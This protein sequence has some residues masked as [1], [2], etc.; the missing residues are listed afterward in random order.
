M[1]QGLQPRSDVLIA[2]LERTHV[3]VFVALNHCP[4]VI[5]ATPALD[6]LREEISPYGERPED[7]LV[8]R[9]HG[10]VELEYIK[11]AATAPLERTPEVHAQPEEPA[12]DVVAELTGVVGDYDVACARLGRR[13]VGKTELLQQFCQGQRAVYFLAAS[14]FQQQDEFLAY[15]QKHL[16][17]QKRPIKIFCFDQ[18]DVLKEWLGSTEHGNV[19]IH[20]YDEELVLDQIHAAMSSGE[21]ESN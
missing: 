11:G 12:G 5:R 8:T 20:K 10:H 1:P 15:Y 9:K 18:P 16:A 3:L 7:I 19:E 4:D 6:V 13:R 17:R 21:I 14:D 2:V